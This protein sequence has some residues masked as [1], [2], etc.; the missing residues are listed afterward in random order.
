MSAALGVLSQ[1]GAPAAAAAAA[2]AAATT[3]EQRQLGGGDMP[4]ELDEFGRDVNAERRR[5]A[6]ERCVSLSPPLAQQF[7]KASAH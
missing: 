6:A 3:A 7:I 2:D 1:G 5:E 4:V